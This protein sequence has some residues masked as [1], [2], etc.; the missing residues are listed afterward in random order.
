M[1]E[2]IR[3]I[4]TLL[5]EHDC[6]IIPGFGGFIT[7]YTPARHNVNDH[8]FFPPSKTVGFNSSLKINDGLLIQ[9]YMQAHETSYPRA[10]QMLEADM[11]E[12]HNRLQQEG[13]VEFGKLG[14][15]YARIDDSLEF[16]PKKES[17]PSPQLYGLSLFHISPLSELPKEKEIQ[18]EVVQEDTSKR[19]N[20]IVININR[21]WLSNVVAIAA[22]IILF[23]VLST[24]VDNTYVEPESYASIGNANWFTR[25]MKAS[26]PANKSSEGQMETS[27]SSE[28][29][30]TTISSG[31]DEKI[32]LT[33]EENREVAVLTAHHN[34][35]SKS[36]TKSVSKS[37]KPAIATQKP[38]SCYHIIVGSVIARKNA[39]KMVYQLQSQGYTEASIVEGDGRVRIAIKSGYDKN[40]I[41]TEMIKL[42]QNEAFKNAWLLTTHTP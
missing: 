24:P 42:R 12:L 34:A 7:Y 8:S 9:A 13:E 28:T 38:R 5:L 2:L 15:L 10:L 40:E 36:E 27:L 26:T 32:N 19:H 11:M 41:N 35:N 22:A 33:K 25:T 16:Q 3:H 18:A 21:T 37:T 23:Y 29:M 14:V 1:E 31:E 4:E 17:I 20:F 6:V 30:Q 39:E